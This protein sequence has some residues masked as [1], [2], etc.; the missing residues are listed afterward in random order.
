MLCAT[1]SQVWVTGKE[2][3]KHVPY[4]PLI[5]VGT[6]EDRDSTRYRVC[7]PG[8]RLY[9]NSTSVFD[10]EQVVYN[11]ETLLSLR[12]IYCGDINDTLE[13]TL[14]MVSQEG[15][16]R[17]YCRGWDVKDELILED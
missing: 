16:N 4:L 7:F 17:N 8:I 3:A 15:E 2:N 5:P 1:D 14:G 12:E 11:L 13:L 9:P 6:T 10:A